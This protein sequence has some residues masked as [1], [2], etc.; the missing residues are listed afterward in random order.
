MRVKVLLASVL[1]AC[2]SALSNRSEDQSQAVYGPSI[3]SSATQEAVRSLHAGSFSGIRERR[4][5][6]IERLTR[7]K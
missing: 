3:P 6:A 4:R 5:Q 1:V 7:K 2:G